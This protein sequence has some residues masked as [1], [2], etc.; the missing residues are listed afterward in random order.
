MFDI[1]SPN[2]GK[3]AIQT[4]D[5]YMTVTT[6]GRKALNAEGCHF[7]QWLNWE[8]LKS[9]T[10]GKQTISIYPWG[11]K[12]QWLCLDID[13]GCE[14]YA[15]MTAIV[16]HMRDLGLNDILVSF[17]GSKGY[18]VE[19][20]SEYPLSY[21]QIN[22]LG[23][24]LVE[25][26]WEKYKA[27]KIE[28]RPTATMG[29]KLPLGINRKSEA[30]CNILDKDLKPYTYEYEE[31]VHFLEIKRVPIQTIQSILDRPIMP[32]VHIMP[33][34]LTT[35]PTLA[36]VPIIPIAETQ[37]VQAVQIESIYT[38][39]LTKTNTRHMWAFQI[40]LWARDIQHWSREQAENA[41]TD[42]TLRSLKFISSESEA[43]ADIESIL[44]SV[45]DSGRYRLSNELKWTQAEVDLVRKV[46]IQASLQG[47]RSNAP[48]RVLYALI[49]LVK[50]YRSNPMYASIRS[51]CSNTGLSKESVIKWLKWLIDMDYIQIVTGSY[52]SRKASTYYISNID[53][54]GDIPL[55]SYEDLQNH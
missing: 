7:R 20:F 37:G 50:Y 12:A 43:M 41:L 3:W 14:S 21:R 27:G 1:Y 9:H 25:P 6:E 48:G 28:I 17:S 26:R 55:L 8:E 15:D 46:Q 53:F 32:T 4:E 2:Q 16:S 11:S 30:R 38:Q 40:A 51:I 47:A 33:V 10:Q 13:T 52:S 22:A 19:I 34:E 49:T 36:V 29:I 54:G 5:H 23:E 39:G 42:W 24:R 18:H 31:W 45:Y 44:K 35:G